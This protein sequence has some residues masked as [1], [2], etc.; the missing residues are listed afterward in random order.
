MNH[1]SKNSH[2]G[3]TAV[4]KLD[5]TLGKLG[6]LIKVVP[7]EVKGSVTEVT[8]ELGLS[9][10]ILHNSELKGSD[11]EDDLGKSGARNGVNGGPSV[12]DG[13]EGGSRVV[14]VSWK[15]DSVAGDNLS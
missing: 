14:N 10:N 3:G 11:E 1:K 2:H 5:S 6:L 15:V 7:S 9:G 8:W 4:I 12:G 13:V